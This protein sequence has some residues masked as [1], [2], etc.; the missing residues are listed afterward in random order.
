MKISFH[1]HHYP[2]H[3][4]LNSSFY[5]FVSPSLFSAI[6]VTR[7]SASTTPSY[8]RYLQRLPMP[9]EWCCAAHSV[10]VLCWRNHMTFPSFP[11]FTNLSAIVVALH[12]VDTH[13]G[14]ESWSM[15]NYLKLKMWPVSVHFTISCFTCNSSSP[16]QSSLTEPLPKPHCYWSMYQRCPIRMFENIIIH[17]S[18]DR[19]GSSVK[20]VSFLVDWSIWILVSCFFYDSL[21]FLWSS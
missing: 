5:D 4:F 11:N 18:S 1:P 17:S 10:F 6:S 15:L 19:G 14:L 21:H 8:A 7:L 3:H 20:I 16:L 12:H 13:R 2:H 9:L